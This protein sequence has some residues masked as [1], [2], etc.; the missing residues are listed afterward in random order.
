MNRTDL[1]AC[2]CLERWSEGIEVKI[3]IISDVHGNF[4]ALSALPEQY[5][6]LWVLGD[7]VNYGPEPKEV[8]D[9]V[10]GKAILIVRG[11]HD[12][13]IGYGDD[14]RCSPRFRDMA[15]ATGR[16]TRNVLTP[17]Q[18]LHLRSFPLRSGAV[19]SQ[20][21]F[22]LCHATPTDP[23]YEYRGEDSDRWAKEMKMVK[24]DIVLVG[25]THIPYIKKID[26]QLVVNPGSLGQPKNGCTDACYA[27]WE[28]GRMS[29]RSYP[30]PVNQTIEKIRHMPISR[31]I[32][33]SLATVLESGGLPLM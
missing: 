13:S 8:V 21:R 9:F 1:E 28:N 17:E 31:S 33:Q 26:G 14:P 25:H 30:Y 5:D 2:G 18:K 29:L 10:I 11:N 23:L 20:T 16:F 27:V 6:E 19:R 22:F 32:Q 3:V 4:D 7:L 12:Q 24:S 15:E